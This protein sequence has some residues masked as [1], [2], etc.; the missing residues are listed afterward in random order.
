VQGLAD[1]G[2]RRLARRQVQEG[3]TTNREVE[4]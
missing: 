2:G 1:T 4:R 3:L